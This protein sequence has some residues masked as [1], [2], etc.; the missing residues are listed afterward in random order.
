MKIS[1]SN[2][3]QANSYAF[4]SSVNIDK[5]PKKGA[6]DHF[7]SE[8]TATVDRSEVNFEL[9]AN[10]IVFVGIGRPGGKSFEGLTIHSKDSTIEL[11]FNEREYY[12]IN[13]KA[14]W[15]EIH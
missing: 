6:H 14:V 3:L 12:K 4:K 15:Y 10:S 11:S 5:K 2:D 8:I 7:E 9:E 13:K 1:F